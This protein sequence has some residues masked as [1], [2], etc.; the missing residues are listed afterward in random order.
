MGII[1][2]TTH[3]RTIPFGDTTLRGYAARS[4]ALFYFATQ[5]ASLPDPKRRTPPYSPLRGLTFF[6]Q[7]PFLTGS[8]RGLRLRLSTM[9]PQRDSTATANGNL[10][11]TLYPKFCS[12]TW[13][14][15]L[16]HMAKPFNIR[17]VEPILCKYGSENGQKRG[18][19][20]HTCRKDG[21]NAGFTQV[22][23]YFTTFAIYE[24]TVLYRC[25]AF[26]LLGG[27]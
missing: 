22:W 24:G 10:S 27:R 25:G 11:N 8:S 15:T 14:V 20:G 18:F 2:E 23:L 13:E 6:K 3:R 26:V 5:K 17:L 4:P 12:R 21:L 1:S 19:S 16:G 7:A 9:V